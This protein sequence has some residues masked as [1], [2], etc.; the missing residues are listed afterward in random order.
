MVDA[1]NKS[2]T[3]KDREIRIT[4]TQNTIQ[5]TIDLQKINIY[6]EDKGENYSSILLPYKNYSDPEDLIK[7]VID[8]HPDF[9]KR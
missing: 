1:G 7:D 6:F 9:K 2:L 5:A 3:Y 4:S 8:H